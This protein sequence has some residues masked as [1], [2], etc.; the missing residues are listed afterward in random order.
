MPVIQTRL[1]CC[2]FCKTIL[3]ESEEVSLFDDPVVQPPIENGIAWDL[4][5]NSSSI[6]I[7]EK[8]A[9]PKCVIANKSVQLTRAKELSGS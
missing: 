3:T 9:C 7:R 1:W 4:I 8:L 5:D 2:E 6:K